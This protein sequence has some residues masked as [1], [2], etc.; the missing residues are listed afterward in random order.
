MLAGSSSSI[1]KGAKKGGHG[2]QIWKWTTGLWLLSEKE[3]DENSH[4]K[5]NDT[6]L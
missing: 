1:R 5:I 4:G 2:A 6:I 3:I